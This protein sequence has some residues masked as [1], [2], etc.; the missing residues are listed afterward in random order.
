M[1]CKNCGNNVADGLTRC[2]VCGAEMT[3]NETSYEETAI[4]TA[5]AKNPGKVLGIIALVV[6]ILS[7]VTVF[8][9]NGACTFFIPAIFAIAGIILG[10]VGMVV[11]KKAGYKNGLALFGLIL[12]IIGLILIPI[13]VLLNLFVITPLIQQL[14]N[15]LS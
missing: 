5:P 14:M 11:S 15:E 2:D 13:S 1:Y 8:I 10:I 7:V 3:V 9:C 4:D 12:S 6:S